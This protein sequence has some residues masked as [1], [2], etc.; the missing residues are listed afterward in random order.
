MHKLSAFSLVA[1]H[2][3]GL[4]GFRNAVSPGIQATVNGLQNMC[5]LKQKN[6]WHS[7]YILYMR[8]E[9]CNVIYISFDVHVSRFRK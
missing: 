5:T 2:W 3:E 1:A 9:V 6:C 7:T 4:R 8:F